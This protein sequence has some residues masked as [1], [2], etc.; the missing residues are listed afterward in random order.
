MIRLLPLYFAV[1]MCFCIITPRVAWSATDYV[2]W[3]DKPGTGKWKTDHLPIGNSL[4][5]AGLMGGVAVDSMFLNDNAAFT[6]AG[7]FGSTLHGFAWMNVSVDGTDGFSNFRRDLDLG[8]ATAHVSYTADGKTWK[9]EYF[10]SLPDKVMV[11][12][13]TCSSPGQIGLTVQVVPN[14]AIQEPSVVAAGNAITYTGS[15]PVDTYG[16]WK[17][18]ARFH[19]RNYGGSLEVINGNQIRVKGADTVDILFTSSHNLKMSFAEGLRSTGSLEEESSARIKA[20]LAKPYDRLLSEHVADFQSI[21]NRFTL[22]LNATV[23]TDIPT[24][25]RINNSM[26]G[27]FNDPGLEVLWLQFYRYIIISS[28][29]AQLPA[30]LNGMWGADADFYCG[31]GYYLNQNFE[32][33]YWGCETLNVQE[34]VVPVID[35]WFENLKNSM[36][37]DGSVAAAGGNSG[38]YT[39][40]GSDPSNFAWMMHTLYEHYRFY[41][42]KDLLQQKLWPLMVAGS[43]YYL[44]NMTKELDGKKNLLSSTNPEN[45][46]LCDPVTDAFIYDENKKRV[47]FK[48]VSTAF[49]QQCAVSLLTDTVEVAKILSIE[50]ELRQ[51]CEKLLAEMDHG[52]WISP[53]D[54]RLQEFYNDNLVGQRHHRHCSH[55]LAVWPFDQVSPIKNPD[56]TAAALKAVMQRG[57]NFGTGKNHSKWAFNPGGFGEAIRGGVCARLGDGENAH[58]AYHA[59]LSGFVAPNFWPGV[60]YAGEI[61]LLEAL[62]GAAASVAEMLVQSHVDNKIQLLPALPS[63]WPKGS[64]QGLRCR[65]GFTI[66]NMSWE[67]GKLTSA[68]I[69]S[70]LGNPCKI[71]G[72]GYTVMSS[73]GAPAVSAT[74]SDGCLVFNTAAGATYKVKALR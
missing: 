46:Y 68:S 14:T 65:N 29:R 74:V 38:P 73:D 50:P 64:V 67:G 31:G 35:M 62:G 21:F 52:L 61:N 16:D 10:C 7:K 49:A 33:N 32:M 66:T 30:G 1:V 47:S 53:T 9:R 12:R 70:E 37:N 36:R 23:N 6:S 28:S 39:F 44:I 27:T 56:Y 58:Y 48:S 72:T 15:L 71:Y 51:S 24:D 25:Q 69:R 55:L 19:I 18:N 41:P 8:E 2:M 13:Y 59:T 11:C 22:N 63:A 60:Y 57:I 40:K 3:Y 34:T 20:A 5:G 4:F 26:P 43:K 45:H 17:F 54:G 42:D